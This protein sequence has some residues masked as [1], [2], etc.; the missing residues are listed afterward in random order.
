[1]AAGPLLGGR[2]RHVR[3]LGRGAIG[4]VVEVEDTIAGGARAAKIVSAA[5]GERLQWELA[6]L[7]SISHAGLA[8]V[9][10]LLR[11]EGALGEPF[12]LE[13]GAW[14]LVEELAAGRPSGEVVRGLA[15]V[16]S[17]ARFASIAG[18][19][20]ARALAALH[21]AGLVHGDV[22]PANVVV[23]GDPGA[24]RLVDLGLAGAPGLGPV[25]GTPGFLAPEAWLGARSPSSD[26]FALG[27][28]LA[29]WVAGDD[30]DAGTGARSSEPL[31]DVHRAPTLPTD[32]PAPLRALIEELLRDA[33]E[34][35]P[36][37]A[38]EVA[39]RLDPDGAA[40]TLLDEPSHDERARRAAV[41]RLHGRA[42]ELSALR[43]AIDAPGVIAVIGPPGS[44]RT[45]L[46]REAVRALQADRAREGA[47]VPTWIDDAL[48]SRVGHACVV[49]DGSGA[50]SIERARAAVR[51]AELEGA[52]LV[53]ILERAEVIDAPGIKRVT[54]GPIDDA[55]LGALLADV[56][57]IRGASAAL[58][59]ASRAASSGLPGRLCRI[60]ASAFAQGRDPSRPDV[61]RSLGRDEG[62]ALAVPEVAR[63]LAEAL[64]IAGGT[65]RADEARMALGNDPA[66]AGALLAGSGLATFD[67]TG[68]VLRADRV[69]SITRDLG[70]ARRKAIARTLDRAAVRG[71][72]RACVDAAL[73]RPD[74]ARDAF[75]G[76]A[77]EAR[78][79]GDPLAAADVLRIAR[80]RLSSTP[81]PITL[82][83]AEALRAAGEETAAREALDDAETRDA[84]A[85]AAE[86][87]RLRGDVEAAERGAL[88]LISETD[89]AGLAA[90]FTAARIA[91]GRGELDRASELARSVRDV[92][93]D[94]VAPL[95]RA[96]EVET[97]V[98][99]SRGERETASSL[100]A[101]LERVAARAPRDI[102]L[103]TRA[104]AASIA[105]SAALA[106][107][108]IELAIDAYERAAEHAERAGE[109]HGAASATVNLGLARL[110]AGRLGP[111]I[112]ALRE[113][114]RRLATLRRPHELGRA[115]FN[116]ANAAF[117][118]GDDAL[119]QLAAERARDA[120]R[121]SGD[122][123]ASDHAA[124]VL[125][126]LEL[127]AG[128][129]RGAIRALEGIEADG[130]MLPIV[131]ARLAIAHAALGEIDH[132]HARARSAR[133][134]APEGS[135]AEVEVLLAEARVALAAGESPI[136]EARAMEAS[137]SARTFETRVRAALVG[138][139]AAELE[140]R[141][142]EAAARLATAR[143]LLDRAAAGL[144]PEARARLR[145]VPSYQRALATAPHA[146]TTT[147]A[148]ARDARAVISLARRVAAERRP[149]R[150]LETLA[151]AA[152][153]L[154]GAE[155]AF[156]LSRRESGATTVRCAVGLT[157]ALGPE[158]RASRSIAA[159]V[160]DERRPMVSVDAQGDAR[161]D[162]AASVHA[163][164][165]RSVLAV[166][167]PAPDGST[168]AL[169]LDDR[170]RPG[171][172]DEGTV[173]DVAA[174]AELGAAALAAAERAHDARRD[175]RLWAR[176]ARSLEQTL[177]ARGEELRTFR[178]A[179]RGEGPFA[180]IVSVS[181]PM[182]RVIAL[183]SRVAT[184]GVPVL[185][186]GESGTGKELL[187][188]AIHA[189]SARVGATFVGESCAAIPE[190]L[191]EST[192][193]GHVRGAF[194]GADRA[195]RGLFEIAHEGTLF[196]D[197]IAETSP[198]M[199]AKLLR[200]L[201]EGE[202]RSV[203]SERVRRVDVRLIAASRAD[204]ASL[205]RDGRFREDLYYRIAVVTIEVPALRERPADVAPLAA[206]LL[207]RHAPNR[208]VRID[209]AA[210][211]AMRGYAWPGNVRELEN[212]L[213]RALLVA[214]DTIALE[215]LSPALRGDDTTH[216]ELDL[217][218][219]TEALERRLVER[220]LEVHG[221][222]QTRAAKALGLSRFGLQKMLKRL[223]LDQPK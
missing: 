154:A 122:R 14:V 141:R 69:R 136:A 125:A 179:D 58:Q 184:S 143:A 222:N 123:D 32:A 185:L 49:H 84:R 195:R 159:R 65:L 189:A 107:G 70:G 130:A 98:A 21:A 223:A 86:L 7:T 186:V 83:L 157:G 56:L 205:V 121:E 34:E 28:T 41:A 31:R 94:R 140:G 100:A 57:A 78:A 161:W 53:V 166:P 119:A 147:S 30:D 207:A 111:A 219:Q 44:G 117:L 16:A 92:A 19:A 206:A 175:A 221:G 60:V 167:L 43:A 211:T 88:S 126:D 156:V 35:R 145:A 89:A 173:A 212:E 4:R 42:R 153:E 149:A 61:M 74:A 135:L 59:S 204:L 220:A 210:L 112:D 15:G 10:E 108:A 33:P 187:A 25:M 178:D 208:R 172:F 87:A 9:H 54:L 120:A 215:H 93:G 11:V 158:H 131:D 144:S 82:A 139:E 97:L 51:A 116:L 36:A 214:G 168:L 148:P 162:G 174:L 17:R 150:V 85:L 165:L 169:C 197:E 132:A 105:G 196:L 3:E 133:A 194:T 18:A 6:L 115:L 12:A 5:H 76:I 75:L 40:S 191:L 63:P 77:A 90:R 68:L 48:P 27:V 114:A 79:A 2:Y 66:R 142:A 67:A 180:S 176:R 55:S 201:Q 171:A 8:A 104:R 137:A 24:A 151:G 46:A 128:R 26:L 129:V 163:M 39:R 152:L 160:I 72:A 71:L 192:L 217:K 73:D 209:D 38:R 155:R 95:A 23:A 91:W 109:R 37:S 127:R 113:G 138:A 52:S 164:A 22:K 202:I 62:A 50:I 146:A 218:A 64:A 103:A 193:F 182:R 45:R 101:E 134:N 81:E 181:E 106:S 20:V 1:M 110:D 124:I 199:Q 183:A 47:E 96:L 203:G 80:E 102:A 29:R 213:R 13:P 200:V 177:E 170:L 216:A 190:T 198:A 99:M 188:R 118:A